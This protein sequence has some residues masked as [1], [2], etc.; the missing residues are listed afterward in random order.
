MANQTTEREELYRKVHPP[1][2]PILCN[3]EATDVI[4]AALGN[5]ELRE[6]VAGMRN[7]RSGGAYGMKAE[8]LKG[9]LQGAIS[10]GKEEGQ[11]G[12]GTLWH[13]FV[14]LTQTVWETGTIPQQMLSMVVILI[15]KR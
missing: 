11:E 12:A 1:G 7:G 8:H 2:E 15:P 9:W 10:E 13:V 14:D 6:V 4:D 3:A 5:V